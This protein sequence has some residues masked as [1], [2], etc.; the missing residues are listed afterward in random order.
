[1]IENKYK[2]TVENVNRT[3]K[4]LQVTHQEREGVHYWYLNEFQ[5]QTEW[6]MILKSDNTFEICSDVTTYWGDRYISTDMSY[7][8]K[9]CRSIPKA[10]RKLRRLYEAKLKAVKEKQIKNKLE[11]MEGDFAEC[12]S[13]QN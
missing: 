12:D 7:E 6:I 5:V 13:Q 11:M 10:V 4:D 2:L 1:M 3:V 8:P 9:S